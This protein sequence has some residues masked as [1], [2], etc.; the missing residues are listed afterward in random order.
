MVRVLFLLTGELGDS[1][2]ALLAENAKEHLVTVTDL[3]CETDYGRIV[4]EIAAAD[5]V[6]CW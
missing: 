3:R 1:G 5:R 2:A 4:D 6:I